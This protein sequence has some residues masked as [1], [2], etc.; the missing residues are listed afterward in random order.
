MNLELK[1][2]G[3]SSKSNRWHYGFAFNPHLEVWHI[4]HSDNDLPF[5]ETQREAL[6]AKSSIGQFTGFIDKKGNDI[7]KGDILKFDFHIKTYEVI[8]H[9][10]AYYLRNG[11]QNTRLSTTSL[12]GYYVIGNVFENPEMLLVS[13]AIT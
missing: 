8:W 5:K 1:F 11:N 12:S 9:D 7:Y 4:L 13:Q 10:G 3:Y 6:V 2:R